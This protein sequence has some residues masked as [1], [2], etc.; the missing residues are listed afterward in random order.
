MRNAAHA[1]LCTDGPSGDAN[2]PLSLRISGER[3]RNSTINSRVSHATV[4]RQRI[5][6]PVVLTVVFERV[7]ALF[8]FFRNLLSDLCQNQRSPSIDSCV[9][10]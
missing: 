8:L 2:D 7:C 5:Q 10:I 6:G 3:M 9:M 4:S 1:K